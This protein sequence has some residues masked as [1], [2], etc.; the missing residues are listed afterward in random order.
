MS[1]FEPDVANSRKLKLFLAVIPSN[2]EKYIKYLL[3][4]NDYNYE[5]LILKNLLK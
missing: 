4:S 5:K 2:E 3:L 1:G